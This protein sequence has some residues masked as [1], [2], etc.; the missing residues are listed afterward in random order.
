ML[1]ASVDKFPIEFILRLLLEQ[2]EPFFSVLPSRK[3][4]NVTILNGYEL[5]FSQCLL[6]QNHL[7]KKKLLTFFHKIY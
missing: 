1:A 5:T 6:E 7:G 4:N 3:L 2:T